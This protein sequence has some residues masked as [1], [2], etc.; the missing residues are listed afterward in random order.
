MYKTLSR[1]FY[2]PA[3]AVDCYAVFRNCAECAREQVT[4]RQHS[5]ELKLFP[6]KAPLESVS[7][8]ILGELVTTKRKNCYLLVICD[9]Y[10]KLVRTIPLSSISSNKVTLA[11]L[12]HWVFVYGP[13]VSVLSDNGKQF[14]A[15]LFVDTCR[16]LGIKNVFT[17]TYHPQTNG[18]VE[19]FN[20]TI[21]SALRHYVAEHPRDWD[22]FSDAL[23]YAYNTQAHASTMLAPFELVLSRP[24]PAISIESRPTMDAADDAYTYRERWK[25]WLTQLMSTA[26]AEL[27]KRQARYKRNFDARLRLPVQQISE[28]SFVFVRR[29]HTPRTES[30][31]KLAPVADGP[32]EVV[33]AD[34][35]T[36]VVKIDENVERVSRDRVELAPKP[37][38]PVTQDTVQDTSGANAARLRSLD[39]PRLF[40]ERNAMRMTYQ[41]PGQE[42]ELDAE[43]LP[44]H[45]GILV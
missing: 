30:R 43:Y 9:R 6:A 12:K 4:L 44:C 39:L 42:W 33:G 16:F 35:H 17:T 38:E 31:H 14:T 18:Q 40:R 29:D 45:Q 11:F 23:T 27:E 10:T 13:P 25:Y 21:L 28:G 34:E 5:K 36:V 37:A 24:P 20:R 15:R 22:L 3:L 32:F 41:E 26:S 7:I 8:D 19:R 1:H 2:W